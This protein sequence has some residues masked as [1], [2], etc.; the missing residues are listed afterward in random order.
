MVVI[1][2]AVLPLIVAMPEASFTLRS[3]GDGAGVA[4][5]RNNRSDR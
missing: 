4:R 3:V 2:V 5:R 1:A